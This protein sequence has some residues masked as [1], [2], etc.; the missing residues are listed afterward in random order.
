[1]IEKRTTGLYFKVN[2]KEKE[3]IHQRME[4][5]GIRNQSAFLRKM[6]I[7]GYTIYLDMTEIKELSRLTGIT[8]NNVNQIA[9]IS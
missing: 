5:S 6:A 2:E 3:L 7:D 4:L 8:A 9:Y 1:M